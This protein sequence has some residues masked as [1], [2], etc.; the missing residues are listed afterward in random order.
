MG[1]SECL[2]VGDFVWLGLFLVLNLLSNICFGGSRTYLAP[3]ML[4]G[5]RVNIS[6]L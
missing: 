2:V 5:M 1:S 6:P 3:V 4:N